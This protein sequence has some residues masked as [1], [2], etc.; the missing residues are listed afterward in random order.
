MAEGAHARMRILITGTRAPATLDLARR[1]HKEGAAIIGADSARFPLGRFS[2]AFK[3]HHRVAAPRW[4]PDT[5]RSQILGLAAQEQI[6]LIIPTCEEMFHL[7]PLHGHLPEGIEL[8]CPPP[9]IC[10]LLHHKLKFANYTTKPGAQIQSPASWNGTEAPEDGQLIWKPYYSRFGVQTLHKGKPRE[11]T[12][13]MAQKKM[14]GK[15]VSSWAWCRNGRVKIQTVYEGTVRYKNGAACAFQP[16]PAPE[17]HRFV[18]EIAKQTTYTGFLAFDFITTPEGKTWVLECN[19]RLTSG[20]HILNP[21]TKLLE[22]Q[23]KTT[24]DGPAEI[25]LATLLAKPSQAGKLADV[26]HRRNDPWPTIGQMV[27]T[28]EFAQ[29]AWQHKISLTAATTWDIEFNG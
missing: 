1:L 29:T 12:G 13:W 5:F 20:I 28:I 27:S 4:A 9:S 26:I 23:T 6:D 2:R 15:E 11:L 21:E 8:F 17:I 7:A 3:S 22:D 16:Q 24:P 19:P 10:D 14:E 25:F 18:Q